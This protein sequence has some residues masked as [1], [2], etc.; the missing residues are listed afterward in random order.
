LE[1]RNLGKTGMRVSEISLGTW[2]FGGE[3]GMVSDE[4]SYATLNRAIDLGVNFLDTADVYG[5]GRSERL[6]GKL[7]KERSSDE[8]FVATKAGRRLDP[9][10]AEGY[11]YENL[12]RFVDRSL[13]NLRVETL[14]L[15]QL[16]CPP[17][18]VFRRDESFEALDRLQ[19]AG[20]LRNYGVSVE[21]VE[22][23]RMAL[24]Y[25]G[26]KTVQI[27]FNIFRQRPAEEFFPLAG[28]RNV[29]VIARVPLASGLLSGKM[30]AEREFASDDHRNFNREGQAFDRGETFSGVDFETGLAAAEELKELVP[31]GHTLA[32][33]ALRWILM[34]P[35]VSCA[36]PGA[37]SPD[38]VAD[39]LA[40]AEMPPLPEEAMNRIR[41]IYDRHIRPGVHHQW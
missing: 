5:D 3:W 16:H 18:E 34:H 30:T 31:K 35:A 15:L 9:H 26:V 13:A 27:I 32:Q 41:E 6:I 29:G 20:K 33:L 38:Q 37:K 10:T 25:P 19:A 1:Y 39:N 24:G 11:D 2:A 28:E 12:S 40:A 22:E 4:E 23:A 17:T 7:L 21:K 36:I 14:D 8:I